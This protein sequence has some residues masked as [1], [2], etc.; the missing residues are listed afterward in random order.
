MLALL[1]SKIGFEDVF[2]FAEQGDA[3]ASKVKLT[4]L[5]A[6]SLGILN[7]IVAYDPA[8]VVIGGGIMRSKDLI[9]PFVRETIKKDIWV[10][11]YEVEVVAA[12]Q[13]EHAGVLGMAWLASEL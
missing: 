3:L 9:L 11:E 12:E 8:R 10:A 6:W 7:L 1:K 5:K 2:K 4:S 13:V